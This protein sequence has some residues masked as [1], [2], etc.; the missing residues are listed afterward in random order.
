MEGFPHIGGKSLVL[1]VVVRF[2]KYVHFLPLGH[3]YNGV[4][5]AKAFF[6]NVVKLHGGPCSI[7]SDHDP[8][9]TSTF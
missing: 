3:P 7:I 9:F 1:T 8:V 6:D 2:S 4:T 5:V